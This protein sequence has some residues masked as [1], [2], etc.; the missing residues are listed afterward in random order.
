MKRM[1]LSISAILFLSISILMI[2][3][4]SGTILYF[5]WP[6]AIPAAFPG[7]VTSGVLAPKL[8][9]WSAVCLT[10]IFGILIKSNQDNSKK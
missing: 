8:S 1:W 2:A 7:I 6:I 9:W 3:L 5:I 10:W 4:L